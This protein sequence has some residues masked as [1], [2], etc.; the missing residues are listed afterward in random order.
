MQGCGNDYVYLDLFTENID[1]DF[2]QLAKQL[3]NRNF[4][5]GS[6]GLILIKPWADG[7]A[8]IVM[9][10]SDGSMSEMCGNGLRCV[11]KHVHDHYSQGKK[12]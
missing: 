7:D 1:T 11:A 3:S 10:N 8:E 12:N 6:D 9:Y 2:S 5:I 4:G